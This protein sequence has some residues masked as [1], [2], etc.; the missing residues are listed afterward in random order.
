[1][2]NEYCQTCQKPAVVTFDERHGPRVRLCARHY[3]NHVDAA[4]KGATSDKFNAAM[5]RER[6]TQEILGHREYNAKAFELLRSVIATY[7][8]RGSL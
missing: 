7:G 3:M 8:T 2:M 4:G 6:E 1:M 5:K